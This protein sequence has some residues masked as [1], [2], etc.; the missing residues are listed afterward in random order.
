MAKHSFEYSLAVKYGVPEALLLNY[1]RYWVCR[2]EEKQDAEKFHEG[3][4][5]VYDSTRELTRKHEYWDRK[6]WL[7]ALDHLVNEGMLLKGNFNKLKWDRT[8]WYT[9]SDKAFQEIEEAEGGSKRTT[10]VPKEPGVVPKEPTIPIQSTYSNLPNIDDDDNIKQTSKKKK[11]NQ[12]FEP[13]FENP[14]HSKAVDDWE[15]YMGIPLTQGL[16]EQIISLVD[17]V[18]GDIFLEALKVASANNVRRLKYVETVAV[19]MMRGDD[20]GSNQRSNQSGEKPAGKKPG[21]KKAIK[22]DSVPKLGDYI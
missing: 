7:R 2:N 12:K 17:E 20:Y 15:K 10:V 3:R 9:L 22:G 11:V 21:R 16:A 6:V 13:S 4:Y 14:I 5:W 18:G 19:N 1:F 8:C